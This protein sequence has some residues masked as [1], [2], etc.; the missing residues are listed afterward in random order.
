MA[1]MMISASRI[2][3]SSSA[4][5]TTFGGML[6]PGRNAT[7]S[8]VVWR[9][10]KT[11]FSRTQSATWR[12]SFALASTMASAVPH[13]PAPMMAIFVMYGSLV[14]GEASFLASDEAVNVIAVLQNN[15]HGDDGAAERDGQRGAVVRRVER[16]DQE[17]Q[18]RGC[19]NGGERYISPEGQH[20]EPE[21]DG[22]DHCLPCNWEKDAESGGD[23]FASA[24]FEPAGKH[25]AQDG[26][27]RCNHHPK[28]IRAEPV[29]GQPD[30]K[31]AFASIEE[32]CHKTGG[33]ACHTRNVCGANVS[34]AGGTHVAPMRNLDDQI[35]KRNRAEKIR[36]HR[37]E[38]ERLHAEN[39]SVCEMVRRKLRV[40]GAAGL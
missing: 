24:E 16:V 12:D 14:V 4:V 3:C 31:I 34:A 13:P 1:P 20:D 39:L 25:V 6:N 2:A 38:P 11:S 23:A 19:S 21:H 29:N 30:G 33:S 5:I 26:D 35:A 40:H 22:C 36:D 27:D 10:S 18:C 17:R 7:F 8:R 9:D 32:K 28:N 15:Q 37:N